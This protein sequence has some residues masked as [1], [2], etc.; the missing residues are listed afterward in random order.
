MLS[1]AMCCLV[2]HTDSAPS[3]LTFYQDLIIDNESLIGV[4]ITD[5]TATEQG[6][7]A[8]AI[9]DLAHIKVF[10]PDGGYVQTIGQ[11]GRGPGD[12][13]NLLSL[14][15]KDGKFHGLDAGITAKMNLY[16]IQGSLN[17]AIAF[18][19][20]MNTTLP[21]A[22]I[23]NNGNILVKYRPLVSN[24]VMNTEPISSF[25]VIN[26]NHPNLKNRLFD[27]PAREQFIVRDEFG[28]SVV[29]MPF[30]RTNQIAEL[31]GKIFHSWTGTEHIHIYEPDKGEIGSF[32]L[33]NILDVV[34]LTDEDYTNY[35][36]EWFGVNPEEDI[37]RRVQSDAT[38]QRQLRAY[39]LMIEKRDELHKTF[40]F[41][42]SLLSCGSYLWVSAQHK[43]RKKQIVLKLDENG[44]LIASGT[45]PS[46]VSIK[47]ISKGYLYGL[48][49]DEY[50]TPTVVRYSI[51]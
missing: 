18:P 25:Y 21:F 51:H 2:N 41:Y 37:R 16:D 39:A 49:Q 42:N 3:Q 20:L 19:V 35:F 33:R 15:Y 13:L 45:L 12:F 14:E 46:S 38:L 32:S 17:Q 1:L 24:E 11:R 27:S 22:R 34:E 8:V 40:P 9:N 10:S 44:S 6:Y 48:D 31:N 29:P 26:S 4:F 7:I 36:R 43:D 28:F 30:R 47:H 23:L 50:Y 5:V